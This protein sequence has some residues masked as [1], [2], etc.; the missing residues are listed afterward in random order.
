MALVLPFL[1]AENE[2]RQLEDLPPAGFGR[3]SEILL[4]SVRTKSING[5]LQIENYAHCCFC[6]HDS[7][8]IS[9]LSLSANALYDRR[10]LLFSFIN[11]DGFSCH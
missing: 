7:T 4:L 3:L 10:I 6:I 8:H 11:E 2:N 1:S 9:I 5:V